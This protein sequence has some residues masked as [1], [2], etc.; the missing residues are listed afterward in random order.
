[1]TLRKILM[2]RGLVDETLA[3]EGEA[4]SEEELATSSPR[5]SSE[6]LINTMSA[7][8]LKE[9]GLMESY[10]PY[11]DADIRASGAHTYCARLH[12]LSKLYGDGT[13]MGLTDIPIHLAWTFEIGSA[14]HDRLQNQILAKTN[15]IL[16]CWENP[17]TDEVIGDVAD[18]NSWVT[19]PGPGWLFLEPA[20]YNEEYDIGGHTD[21]GVD[22][23]NGRRG[24]LEIK[25]IS[26]TEYDKLKKP[27]PE[28]VIQASIYMWL[29]GLKDSLFL[30]TCKGWCKTPNRKSRKI[31]GGQGHELG[32]FKTFHIPYDG[33]VVLDLMKQ[34]S[35]AKKSFA[36]L[37]E[38]RKEYPDRLPACHIKSA[39]RSKQCPM[40]SLCFEIKD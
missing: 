27:K 21:G 1:M 13:E 14:V 12:M 26:K 11:K 3:D 20:A 39:S 28:H 9:D 25:T 23:A 36:A 38:G 34:I 35:A 29:F 15:I 16:G 30:Y 18:P 6:T 24:I 37:E 32:P 19:Y 4:I 2:K 5:Y 40:S 10:G 31:A 22:L 7:Y 33:S 17:L 8:L